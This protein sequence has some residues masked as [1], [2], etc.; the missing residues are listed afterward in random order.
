MFYAGLTRNK[1]NNRPFYPVV[2]PFI[3]SNNK[4]RKHTLC[5]HK[6]REEGTS[7]KNWSQTIHKSVNTATQNL[8]CRKMFAD[9]RFTRV[10]HHLLL[11]WQKSRL[12]ETITALAS[13][14]PWSTPRL[15][16]YGGRWKGLLLDS[17]TCG[18]SFVCSANHK[19][20]GLTA[21][22]D[23]REEVSLRA[24]VDQVITANVM[25]HHDL[26]ESRCS[27]RHGAVTA[28]LG[29]LGQP[30]DVQQY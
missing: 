10:K 21:G 9:Y 11:T 4:S 17:M 19:C 27:A 6:H 14:S 7:W 18:L 1:T 15:P 26:W 5:T 25:S 23:D 3:S 28:N 2:L 29:L 13:Q 30:S 24:K 16:P 20:V 8:L 12:C 22:W